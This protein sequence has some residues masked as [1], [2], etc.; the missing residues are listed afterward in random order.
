MKVYRKIIASC[1][2]ASLLVSQKQ[3]NVYA[4]T[5]E[6]TIIDVELCD[7]PYGVRTYVIKSDN[8]LWVSDKNGSFYE[9]TDNVSKVF[10]EGGGFM[11]EVTILKTD[12]ELVLYEPKDEY[13]EAVS[14]TLD[15]DV[16]STTQ[17]NQI[18]IKKD[19]NAYKYDLI[20]Y[21]FSDSTRVEYKKT[22]V[23]EN[24]KKADIFSDVDGSLILTNDDILWYV[25]ANNKSKKVMENVQ[26]F[27]ID[28]YDVAILDKKGN[29]YTTSSYG[30]FTESLFS[31]KN[32]IATDVKS[33]DFNSYMEDYAQVA[34]IKNDGSLWVKGKSEL[35]ALGLGKDTLKS[36][37]FTK[38]ADEV[39]D[40]SVEW[41]N[42][43]YVTKD[44]KL[45]G[46]GDNTDKQLGIVETTDDFA[47]YYDENGYHEIMTDVK[48]ADLNDDITTVVK[49]DGSFWAFG[50]NNEGQIVSNGPKTIDT[51]L[52][53][54]DNVYDGNFNGALDSVNYISNTDN[55]LYFSNFESVYDTLIFYENALEIDFDINK[56][57]VEKLLELLGIKNVTYEQYLQNEEYYYN[58]M[59]EAYSKLSE[60]E[61]IVFDDNYSEFVEEVVKEYSTLPYASNVKMVS[62]SYYIDQNNDVYKI[63]I[64]DSSKNEKIFSGAKYIYSNDYRDETVF[65]VGEDSELYVGTYFD[66]KYD[67]T[68]DRDYTP[69]DYGNVVFTADVYNDNGEY[70]YTDIRTA[71]KRDTIKIEKLGVSDVKELRIDT[72]NNS[73]LIK[74]DGTMWLIE[75]EYYGAIH[76]VGEVNIAING[77]DYKYE[78]VAEGV[79]TGS[80]AENSVAYVDENGVLW[81]YGANYEDQLGSKEIDYNEP[82]KIME[83]VKDVVLYTNATIVLKNDG[84]LLG[85]GKNAYGQLGFKAT[86][87]YYR[88]S[89][90]YTP[91]EIKVGA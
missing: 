15:T 5:N 70:V 73:Y 87:S 78:L 64:A 80:L 52:K 62:G 91:T 50:Y 46:M 19:N 61:A 49:N 45:Y 65:I 89:S 79:V 54:A 21:E 83:D 29:L 42:I 33:F 84:T 58:L 86:G 85:L 60:E 11:G 17:T 23:M 48:S 8:T 88:A 76:D 36:E 38:I 6:P 55:S 75:S 24:A 74:N 57:L 10:A 44:G 35:G 71:T 81:G 1:L 67:M 82:T 26:D 14:F 13:T 41:G 69:S 68:G 47:K 53:I 32:L 31:E 90:V 40:V 43:V 56:V 77:V 59:E 12:G 3:L 18:V 25:D 66:V 2:V 63:N 20:S 72:Y 51:P 4:E 30:D 34:I 7:S 27:K 9:V 37:E 28:Y 39:V 16:V 22:L